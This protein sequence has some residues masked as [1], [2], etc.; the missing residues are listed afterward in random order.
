MNTA[1][2]AT[3]KKGIL[4]ARVETRQDSLCHRMF[5]LS[6]QRRGKFETFKDCAKNVN[7][8]LCM[9]LVIP[10]TLSTIKNKYILTML[11]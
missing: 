8:V 1:Y 3:G 5:R 7:D 10:L 6:A 2:Y 9:D 11:D 4:L